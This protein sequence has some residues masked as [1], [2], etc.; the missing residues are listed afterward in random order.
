M[1]Y[2]VAHITLSIPDAVYTEMKKH[3]E[4]KWS[5]IARQSIIEKSQYLKGIIPA[6][7]FRKRLSP[8]AK[9]ALQTIP[10]K[11]WKQQAHL[12]REKDRR[13][14]TSLTRT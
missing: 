8:E 10:E 12:I 2:D 7:H 9:K 4:I 14:V 5:E 1:Y 11:E 6:S 13:R 3:P